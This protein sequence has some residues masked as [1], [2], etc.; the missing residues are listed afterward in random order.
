VRWCVLARTRYSLFHGSCVPNDVV[1]GAHAH[2][3]AAETNASAF[4]QFSI[5]C[6]STPAFI[7]ATCV[8][9]E[10]RNNVPL[11]GEIYVRT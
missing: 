10:Q 9:Q 7:P 8:P 3:P 5:H 6:F 11:S 1:R 4:L 2:Q